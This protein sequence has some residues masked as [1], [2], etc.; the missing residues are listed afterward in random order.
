MFFA[1][2]PLAPLIIPP[3]AFVI[4]WTFLLSPRVGYVNQA[5]RK[6]PWWSSLGPLDPFTMPMIVVISGLV[7]PF[8][9]L[10][11]FSALGNISGELEAAALVSGASERRA[12]FTVTLPLIRPALVYAGGVVLLLGLGQFSVPLLLGR[13]ESINVLTTEMYL[14]REHYPID[15]GLAAMLGIPLV[16]VGILVIAAQWRALGDT[17][18]FVT[19]SGRGGN[20]TRST[21]SRWTYVPVSLFGIFLILAPLLALTYVRVLTVLVRPARAVRPHDASRARG[22]R[23]P[24]D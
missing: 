14:L 6:L 13:R 1:P 2:L 7:T 20:L 17:R 19:V 21:G 16:I 23:R 4:G 15:Y 3:V 22:L 11:V 9:Y 5:L 8:V 18:R 24:A 12:F 10:F